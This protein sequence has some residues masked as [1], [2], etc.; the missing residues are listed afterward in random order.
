MVRVALA[1]PFAL[2]GGLGA[3]EAGIFRRESIN[4]PTSA[5]SSSVGTHGVGDYIISG[6]LPFDTATTSSSQSSIS[7]SVVSIWTN[8][9]SSVAATIAASATNTSLLPATGN[10]SDYATSCAREWYSYSIALGE[11]YYTYSGPLS[12]VTTTITYSRPATTTWTSYEGS[13]YT[14]CDG[15]PRVNGSLPQ[16]D[17]HTSTTTKRDFYTLI[18]VKGNSLT[19]PSCSIQPSDCSGVLSSQAKSSFLPRVPEEIPHNWTVPLAPSASVVVVDGATTTL[20]G[21]GPITAPPAI[22]LDYEHIYT[23]NAGTTYNISGQLLSPG[24]LITVNGSAYIDWIGVG[25]PEIPHCTTEYVQTCDGSCTIFGGEVQL[26]YFPVPTTVSRNMCASNTVGLQGDPR[27]WDFDA[28]TIRTPN[29][30]APP[31][32][33]APNATT[34]VLNGT[35]FTSGWAYISFETAYARDECMRTIGKQHP[36]AL[37]SLPSSA[38]YS[39]CDYLPYSFHFADLN[40]PVPWAAYSGMTECM[41][42]GDCYT[43]YDD[44]RPLLWVPETIRDMDPAWAS[45]KPYWGGLYDPPVAL[46]SEGSLDTPEPTPTG[47][48]VSPTSTAATGATADPDT[49]PRTTT[50]AALPQTT[51]GTK[52]SSSTLAYSAPITSSAAANSVAAISVLESVANPSPATTGPDAAGV[53]ASLFADSSSISNLLVSVPT[54]VSSSVPAAAPFATERKSQAASP[55]S[56]SLGNAAGIIASLVADSQSASVPVQNSAQH[57]SSAQNASPAQTGNMV[58]LL[59]TASNN[60]GNLPGAVAAQSAGPSGTAAALNTLVIVTAPTPAQHNTPSASTAP[61][62][63]LGSS[64]TVSADASTPGA[65]VIGSSTYRPGNTLTINSTPVSVGTGV[66]LV[67]SGS[68]ASS[69]PIIAP[70]AAPT[71]AP[72]ATIGLATVYAAP[73]SGAVVV[74]GTTYHPG[75]APATIANTPFSVGTGGLIIGGASGST[76]A[77]PSVVTHPTGAASSQQAVVTLAGQ[78]FT[79]NPSA[80]LSLSSTTLTAGGAAVTLQNGQYVSVA[81]S[82]VVVGSNTVVFSAA[83]PSAASTKTSAASRASTS[84]VQ[85]PASTDSGTLFSGA[86]TRVAHVEWMFFMLAVGVG[87]RVVA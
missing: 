33:P 36:G 75:D 27:I 14:L 37:L 21:T 6:L 12:T 62:V 32:T 38:V 19:M 42:G 48:T 68:S 87:A 57:T 81:S 47:P 31:F 26:I 77:V 76:I 86:G 3:A 70:A 39:M 66:I 52:V 40:S 29:T 20:Q 59:P 51:T 67:G 5:S 54:Q 63:I 53:V 11:A 8:S 78:T 35:T 25:R 84:A 64:Y 83:T 79:V 80:G 9:S 1:L 82:G 34:A 60:A 61:L 74:G 2:Y 28:I 65:V 71:N 55:A 43:I 18:L 10:G 58:H 44:Y 4:N 24:A 45:C 73:S 41:L 50:Q 17:V 85:Q 72:I 13:L 56:S 23:A 69:I 15:K 16:Q 30:T 46:S 22:T 7:T 49:A